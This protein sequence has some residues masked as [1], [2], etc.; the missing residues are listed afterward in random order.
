[1]A[2]LFIISLTPVGEKL[3]IKPWNVEIG[4]VVSHNLE[5]TFLI[6]RITCKE[7]K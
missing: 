5:I 6:Y 7:F 2:N 3:A 4:L 1:M